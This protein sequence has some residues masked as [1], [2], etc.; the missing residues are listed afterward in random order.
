M[1]LRPAHPGASLG[2]FPFHFLSRFEHNKIIFICLASPVVTLD[3]V[4]EFS[5]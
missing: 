4:K 3:L 2:S 5:A 1:L